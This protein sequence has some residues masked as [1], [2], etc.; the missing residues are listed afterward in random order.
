MVLTCTTRNSTQG[1]IL[2][3]SAFIS[4]LI[5]NGSSADIA[6]V[7]DYDPDTMTVTNK[8]A[9]VTGLVDPICRNKNLIWHFFEGC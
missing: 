8:R 4:L 5:R 6:W 2:S 1:T 3:L 7:W 9:L